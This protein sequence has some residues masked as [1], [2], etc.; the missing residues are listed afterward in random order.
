MKCVLVSVLARG[1]LFG[2]RGGDGRGK[3]FEVLVA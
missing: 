2:G 3:G 1:L